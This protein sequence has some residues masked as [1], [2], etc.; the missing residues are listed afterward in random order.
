ML[1]VEVVTVVTFN[2]LAPCYN[3]KEGGRQAATT[4]IKSRQWQERH[5]AKVVRDT[6]APQAADVICLQEYWFAPAFLSLYETEMARLGYA[7]LFF[8]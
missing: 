1:P 4:L 2:V 6:L 7:V 3:A 5:R 8:V